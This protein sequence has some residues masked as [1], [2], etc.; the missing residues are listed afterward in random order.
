M[1]QTGSMTVTLSETRPGA[2]FDSVILMQLQQS[3]A[4]LDGVIDAGVVMATPANRNLLE[5]SELLEQSDAGPD[6]LLIVVKA[7]SEKSAIQALGMVDQLLA[8]RRSGT[9]SSFHPRSLAAADKQMPAARL[10]SISVPGRFAAGVAQEALDL[11]K[12]VFIYSDNV[13]LDDEL[14]L[15]KRGLDQRLLVMGPDCGTAIINGIG[16]GFSNRVRRGSIGLVGASGTGLQTITSRIHMRGSGVSQA[17]G[18]GGRDLKKAIGAITTLQGLSILGKDEET[19]V[20]VLVSK[21][22]EQ[23]VAARVLEA[24][25]LI[26]KPVVVNFIGLPIAM[27]QS[28]NL[29]FVGNMVESAELAVSLDRMQQGEN[30][31]P[32]ANTFGSAENSGNL[33]ALFSGGTLAYE[34]ILS[35]Q[36]LLSPLFTNIPVRESQRLIDI[37]RSQGHTILDM[38]EDDFTQ[39]RLH[40]MMDN[41]LRIRRMMKEADDPDVSIIMF[42]VVLGEGAHPDPASELANGVEKARVIAGAKG[43]SLAFLALVVGTDEDP[44]DIKA[45][46]STLRSAGVKVF[47]DTSSMVAQT[48]AILKRGMRNKEV[49][50]DPAIITEPLS[51]INIGLELFYDSLKSQGA[52]AVHVDWRPPAGGNENLMSLLAK[53]KSA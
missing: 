20:I 30:M 38:G 44:Q 8:K 24:A 2:Y 7:E 32:A 27:K 41:D 17:I 28:G 26:P 35:F 3:L 50:V 34:T 29:H 5:A 48:L 40:P 42:D 6:D 15:K 25:R 16:L 23:D 9:K 49:F 37:N 22:P 36:S 33:R 4:E 31:A 13:S 11:G 45:Q 1:A 52:E 19:A 43:R 51:V 53:M 39:G 18:S 46:E 47:G 14:S 21:P 12:H 10:V